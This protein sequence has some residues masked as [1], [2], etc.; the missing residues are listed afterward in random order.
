MNEPIRADER[1]TIAINSS[2]LRMDTREHARIS[3]VDV[4]TAAAWSHVRLGRALLRLASEYSRPLRLMG[5]TD[6]DAMLFVGKLK[7]MREVCEQ[8]SLH[9]RESGHDKPEEAALSIIAWW[10]QRT[11]RKCE[12]RGYDSIPG[13][14]RLSARQCRSCD[15]TGEARIPHGETGKRIAN[16]MDE[17]VIA[18]RGSI[19]RSL[20]IIQ[21]S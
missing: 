16:W 18:T 12:G 19:R 10:L 8:V 1:Y 17:C 2:N 5:M 4:C 20:R 11:C 21:S 9:L 15:G 6:T 7:T 3:D 14:G 13:T